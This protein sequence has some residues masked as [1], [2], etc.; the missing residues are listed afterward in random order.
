MESIQRMHNGP[1]SDRSRLQMLQN[2]YGSGLPARMSIERQI[3]SRVERLPGL[4]SS[5]L[6]LESLTGTLDDFG[7]ESYL[8]LPQDSEVAPPDMHSV[9]ETRLGMNKGG[10]STKPMA[11][12]LA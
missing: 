8:G 9:M 2:V 12:G 11:R 5:K 6:G 4:T 3:L 7:F 1:D 10:S